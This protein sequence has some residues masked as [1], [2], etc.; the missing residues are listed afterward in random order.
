MVRV[1]KEESFHQRQGYE[2]LLVMAGVV[3]MVVQ[4][5]GHPLWMSIAGLL[6]PIPVALAGAGLASRRKP[7]AR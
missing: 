1:C 4:L 6:L 5:P 7:A 2:A 3:G